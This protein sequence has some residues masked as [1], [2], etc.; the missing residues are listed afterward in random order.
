MDFFDFTTE[1]ND[2]RYHDFANY[3]AHGVEFWN[4]DRGACD[5]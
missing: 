1:R 4:C 5:E 2:E 3:C